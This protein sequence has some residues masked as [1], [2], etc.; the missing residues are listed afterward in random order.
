MT[1]SNPTGTVVPPTLGTASATATILD[2]DAATSIAISVAEGSLAVDEGAGT[3]TFTVTRTGDAAGTQTVSYA[4]G[5]TATAADLGSSRLSGTVTFNQGD[6]T[7]K[8]IT[9][10]VTDDQLDELDETVTVTLS[11]PT[12]TVVP[13]TL[14]TASATATILDND[15]ATSIAISVAEG[16]LA[17][18]EGAGTITFTVTRTGDAAGTQTVSYAVGGTATA[19][20]LGSPLSGHRHLQPRRP[21]TKTI[22]LTVTDDQ[23]DELDETVTVTLS[24]PTGTVVPPTLGTASATATI[25]DNDA[26]TS[27]AISVAEGSLAVDEGAGTITFTV[28]RTGDAA[29]TQTVSYA[30]GG[31]AT[32]ADLGSP[33]SGT[34]TF[35]QGDPATKTITLTVTDDQLD[36]LDETVTVTLSNPTG[37]VVPPTLGTASATATILDNDAA[38]SIAISVAEGS[39]AV[40]EGA[41]TITFTVTRTGDAAGTQTVSYAVGGTATAADLGS[42]ALRHGHLQPRRPHHQDHHAHRH[43]RPAR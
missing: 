24:N 28:T 42:A 40:D 10:T 27:I 30:V 8:T 2:N 20:D 31:T 14:G 39:L 5:G 32:A 3:I 29:G 19:A 15:A 1:L 6:P 9:L 35:N 37:T 43:G 7:T 16:S 34:V 17:V 38:T 36:E 12:G 23:L 21:T 33:L 18:D 4:V 13:P 26:A 25:L 41:G 11:N 22:T